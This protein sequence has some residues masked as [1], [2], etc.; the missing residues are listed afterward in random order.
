MNRYALVEGLA[1]VAVA[2]ACLVFQ[3]WLPSTHVTD[4]DY[5]TLAK[6]MAAEALPGDGVLL[7][8]WWTERARRFLPE[9]V[10]VTG[11]LGSDRD[12]LEL[13]PRVWLV[14][15]PSLPRSDVSS[16][17][18]DFGPGR[19]EVGGE[20]RF[21]NLSLRLFQNG[22][23]RPV[24]FSAT[25][26]L[27]RAAVY[28]EQPDGSRQP[29]Q[30][31]GVSHQCPNRFEVKTEWHELRYVPRRCVHFNPP[32]GSAKLVAEFTHVPAAESL[33]MVGGLIWEHAVHQGPQF[34]TTTLTLEVN[35]AVTQLPL[36]PGTDGL[37]RA[38][39]ERTPDD[40]TVRVTVSASNPASRETCFELYA[41]GGAP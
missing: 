11:Y 34:S 29:C 5:E 6:V 8:P 31:N 26:A 41:F 10:Q 24:R 17:M 4:A 15:Q 32:G 33:A 1:A 21:G 28:L 27:A 20:R 22:R 37:Q 12:P 7:Y 39:A 25:E 3:L 18:K 30:W 13:H 35:G 19:T 2:I 16:F 38:P 14:S 9:G 23:Y 36:P 40:A